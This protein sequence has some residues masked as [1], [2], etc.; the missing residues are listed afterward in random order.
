M[1]LAYSLALSL[2]DLSGSLT[3][4]FSE[5]HASTPDQLLERLLL[6][7]MRTLPLVFLIF[8]LSL[9]FSPH[10]LFTITAPIF[11]CFSSEKEVRVKLSPV[12]FNLADVLRTVY[13]V[14][15]HFPSTGV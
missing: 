1:T 2:N 13:P 15:I 6:L 4:P 10:Q 12:P 14:L 3:I 8:P 7:I 11:L 9:G 5:R